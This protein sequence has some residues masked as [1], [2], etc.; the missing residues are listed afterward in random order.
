MEAIWTIKSRWM[1][2]WILH[3]FSQFFVTHNTKHLAT[4]FLHSI[5]AQLYCSHIICKIT[6]TTTTTAT[7]NT[8][9]YRLTMAIRAF[10]SHTNPPALR[11]SWPGYKIHSNEHNLFSY[12]MQ[13]AMHFSEMMPQH[14]HQPCLPMQWIYFRTFISVVWAG[15]GVAHIYYTHVTRTPHTP[16]MKIN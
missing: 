6:P 14:H 15:G 8:N 10:D 3:P 2:E 9:V 11:S 4:P 12:S 1:N 16:K 13:I 7:T 5:V